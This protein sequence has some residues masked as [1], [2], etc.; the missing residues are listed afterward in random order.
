MSDH[1]KID[2][3]R[4]HKRKYFI[5]INCF[6]MVCILLIVLLLQFPIVH[7]E[8]VKIS[9]LYF[10]NN[11]LNSEDA[12]SSLGGEPY[13]TVLS[14]SSLRVNPFFDKE[15]ALSYE[16]KLLDMF[17]QTV[18]LSGLTNPYMSVCVNSNDS[19]HLFVAFHESNLTRYCNFDNVT[20]GLDCSSG[21]VYSYDLNYGTF[22]YIGTTIS[23]SG[24]FNFNI[25]L[26]T[27]PI[28]YTY[29]P[30]S[31]SS[32]D[33]NYMLSAGDCG[34]GPGGLNISGRDTSASEHKRVYEGSCVYMQFSNLNTGTLH[35]VCKSDEY[36]RTN[37]FFVKLRV[38]NS[39]QVSE[40]TAY[41][42]HHKRVGVDGDYLNNFSVPNNTFNRGTYAEYDIPLS[43]FGN[44][45]DYSIDL[46]TLNQ[47]L[48]DSNER[49]L[50]SFNSCFEDSSVGSAGSEGLATIVWSLLSTVN[51]KFYD[52]Y[53][54]DY[55]L[56]LISN[57]YDVSVALCGGS[58]N[59]ATEEIFDSFTLDMV[60]GATS[61]QEYPQT[62]EN[63]VKEQL[64]TTIIPNNY[65]PTPQKPSYPDAYN[66]TV[67]NTPSNNNDNNDTNNNNVAP[68]NN[69]NVTNGDYSPSVVNNNNVTIEQ[70]N[71]YPEK[72]VMNS[73]IRI[74]NNDK[75]NAVNDVN[76]LV[77]GNDFVRLCNNV[78][79]AVP[80]QYWNVWLIALKA[81]LGIVVSA[82]FLKILI[83]WST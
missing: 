67:P 25:L 49:S 57:V 36:Q 75:N 11:I 43:A 28:I 82:F 66:I 31:Y 40:N 78:L 64:N 79:Y 34:S 17:E 9:D 42:W 32:Y 5:R 27:A 73:F 48:L 35:I 80:N 29:Y 39:T 14:S 15:T 41:T 26:S 81:I 60:S 33:Y 19:S 52:K 69:N 12:L 46:S 58:G 21:K 71:K 22:S 1:K 23:W 62:T 20:C 54:T 37:N 70:G 24:Q 8:S 68:T 74:I 38:S 53:E 51:F 16:E 10:F 77:A 47:G 50:Y 72:G 45:G 65:V 55:N 7:A 2:W 30:S 18:D 61:S 44:G 4:W 59:D 3:L 13:Q 6:I 56:K 83:N 63:D 76:Q